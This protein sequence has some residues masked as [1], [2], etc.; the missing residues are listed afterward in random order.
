MNPSR[1]TKTCKCASIDTRNLHN[2]LRGILDLGPCA[3][4]AWRD[5]HKSRVTPLDFAS[6]NP[7]ACAVHLADGG[8]CYAASSTMQHE[9]HR[10]RKLNPSSAGRH[11]Q[12]ARQ[13]PI[14][15]LP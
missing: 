12:S 13:V 7:S 11:S 14:S 15:E 5:A 3:R 4:A 9:T 1:D 2:C 6:L 8:R 10:S